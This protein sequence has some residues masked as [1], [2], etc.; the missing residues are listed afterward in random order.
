MEVPRSNLS[1]SCWPTPQPQQCGIWASSVTHTTVHA[2]ARSLTHW[3]MTGIEPE[4]SWILVGFII[5]WALKG[6]PSAPY[7]FM[8]WMNNAFENCLP[9]NAYKYAHPKCLL[10]L[11]WEKFPLPHFPGAFFF[12]GHQIFFNAAAGAKKQT[13]KQ[14]N[15]QTKPTF[16]LSIKCNFVPI[17]H[18]NSFLLHC[19]GILNIVWKLERPIKA[20]LLLFHVN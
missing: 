1:Y 13:N 2:N 5:H 15:K 18:L 17:F 6:A 11:Q 20:S 9:Q 8:E 16:F 4:S 7:I 14:T 12:P 10:Q 3:A 19:M